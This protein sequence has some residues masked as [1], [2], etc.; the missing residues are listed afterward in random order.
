MFTVTE[1]TDRSLLSDAELRIAIGDDGSASDASITALGNRVSAAIVRA[2]RVPAAGATPPTLRLET[3]SETFRLKSS[4]E[5][6]ILSRRPIVS[7]TSIVEN[8]ETL[9]ANTDYESHAAAGMIK[10]LSDDTEICWPSG[11]IVVVAACG[12][13]TVPDDLKLAAVKLAAVFWSEGERVDPNLKAVSIPGVID[14]EYWV[15][16]SDDPAMPREVLDLLAPYMNHW[17]G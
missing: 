17:V 8:D 5:S 3:I 13:E 9:T 10:R 6:L 7:V 12:W 2:C 15:S 16:P 4:Q 11:K 1:N 14:R